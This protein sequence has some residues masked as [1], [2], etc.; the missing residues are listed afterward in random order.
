M[1]GNKVWHSALQ[2]IPNVLHG[3]KVKALYRPLELFYIMFHKTV[4]MDLVLGTG[5]KSC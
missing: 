4:F 3:V 2:F 1:S 5:P